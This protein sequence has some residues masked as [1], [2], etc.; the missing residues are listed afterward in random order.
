MNE[1]AG[2]KYIVRYICLSLFVLSI[3]GCTSLPKNYKRSPS[4]VINNTQDTRLA[5]LS[6]PTVASHRGRSGFFPLIEGMDAFIARVALIELAER[7]LDIQYY[8]WR[9][10]T[11][12]IL[13]VDRLLHAADR[14]VRVRLLLDDLD[15][16]GKDIGLVS[17]AAHPNIEIRLYNP[18]IHRGSRVAGFVTDLARV[19]RRMHNKSLT[20]DNQA[21]IVGGR[22]IGNEYFGARSYAEFSDID[23]L[24]LGPVVKD[25]STMFDG[26]WNSKWVMPIGAL[27]EE[28][29]LTIEA[30]KKTRAEFNK[31]VYESKS[32]PYTQA[33]LKSSTLKN[34]QY[35][36]MDF[37]WGKAILIYDHPGKVEAT[38]VTAATH[39]APK[40]SP[41]MKKAKKELIVI[42]PYFVPG[43]KLVEY[44]G[45]IVN[46]GVRVRILTN[47]LSANDV[48]IVHAGYMRYRVEMLKRGIELYEYKARP[49]ADKRA[50]GKKWSGSS[51][52]SLHAK[53]FGLDR[54]LMF[55]GS[56]NLDPRSI[57][58]NTE[59]GVLFES[60]ELAGK[61]GATF[62]QNLDHATYK[63]ELITTAAE[64]SDSGFD[65]YNLEWVTIE[66][67]KEIRYRSEPQTNW[68]Q[69]LM[70]GFLSV[71]VIE[72]FL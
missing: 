31:L 43:E 47:S 23:V 3:N 26:Y 44:L 21:T 53:T 32:G 5:R 50:K 60:P 37:F 55:V 12:G 4:Y 7:S 22:N 66:N 65:E 59:M 33:I 61:L 41:Y 46:K 67:G 17:L 10:D 71:F 8:I 52:V 62:D 58:P 16:E 9:K 63:L 13:L 54:R 64:D 39:L 27:V 15:T 72:S 14:G 45:D 1:V 18:F 56:F 68:W 11:T 49:G 36:K 40:L 6:A 20:A 2:T 29:S 42:S 38:E 34:L 35:N 28:Q 24:T 69:R 51:K 30:L 48:G 57:T 70:T 19:N 25:V